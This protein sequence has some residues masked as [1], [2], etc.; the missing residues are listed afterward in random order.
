ESDF[1][2]GSA[3]VYNLLEPDLAQKFL[4]RKLDRIQET[5]AEAVVSANPGCT[6]QIEKGLKERGLNIRVL[7]PMEVLDAAYRGSIPPPV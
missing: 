3:G 7:H 6:F 1:C 2:C 5:G 4:N